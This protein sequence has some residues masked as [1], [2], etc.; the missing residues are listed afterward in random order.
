MYKFSRNEL[1]K[2]KERVSLLIKWICAK[3]YRIGKLLW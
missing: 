1:I 3:V 2:D